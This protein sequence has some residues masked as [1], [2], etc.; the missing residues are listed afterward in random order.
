MKDPYKNML[1]ED[2]EKLAEGEKEIVDS[3][4]I[5]RSNAKSHLKGL[6]NASS[7]TM[8]ESSL[9]SADEVNIVAPSET[10]SVGGTFTMD[11][12]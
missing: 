2:L 11:H 1:P 6:V 8:K 7:V 5:M 3:L 4:I 12:S 10:G 9:A